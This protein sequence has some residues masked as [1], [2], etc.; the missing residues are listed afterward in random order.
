MVCNTPWVTRGQLLPSVPPGLLGEALEVLLSSNWNTPVSSALLRANPKHSP[1]QLLWRD[2]TLPQPKQHRLPRELET[3]YRSLSVYGAACPGL[4]VPRSRHELQTDFI[5]LLL[6]LT[7]NFL[8]AF[9]DTA[10][11]GEVN[12]R[13]SSMFLLNS[14]IKVSSW[15]VVCLSKEA[16][17]H[18]TSVEES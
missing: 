7:W 13:E 3:F 6:A 16:Q 12:S 10:C 2:L 5:R 14:V 17:K 4:G 15:W 9:C 11:T 1:C 8:S 18:I